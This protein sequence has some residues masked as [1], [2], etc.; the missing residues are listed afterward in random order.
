[1]N[2]NCDFAHPW[3]LTLPTP[4]NFVLIFEK[5]KN[6]GYEFLKIL[7]SIKTDLH[8]QF[9]GILHC[10]FFLVEQMCILLCQYTLFYRKLKLYTIYGGKNCVALH[11]TS[12]SFFSTSITLAKIFHRVKELG[13]QL[14]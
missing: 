13:H 10:I 5:H 6:G 9:P 12:G 2:F 14:L 4:W 7:C 8:L 1:M 3:S 11:C